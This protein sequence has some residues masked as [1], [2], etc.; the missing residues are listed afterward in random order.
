M[1]QLVTSDDKLETQAGRFHEQIMELIRK[2]QFR[3]RNATCC[4]GISVSQ[5]YV[6]EVLKREGSLTMN[7]LADRMRLSVSTLTR[8]V[9]QLGKKDLVRRVE[10]KRDRRVR[11]VS[12]SPAGEAMF[13]K[14]WSSVLQSERD[15]LANFPEDR[16]ELLIQFLDLLNDSVD[17]WQRQCQCSVETDL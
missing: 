13:E 12:L 10:G 2:Y 5:C 16:R 17:L 6:L 3:D 14:L 11:R 1:H 9:D 8:V 4:F 15:I 7:E